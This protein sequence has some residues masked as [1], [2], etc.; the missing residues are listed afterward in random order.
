MKNSSMY[1]EIMDQYELV[2]KICTKRWDEAREINLILKKAD[3]IILMGTGASLNA[4][5]GAAE[6]ITKY[7]KKMP[8]V[9]EMA[10]AEDIL[11]TLTDKTVCFL[12]SQSGS[13]K[14]TI[15]VAR[16]VGDSPALTIAVT[17]NEDSYLAQ[18]SDRVLLLNSGKEISSATKTQTAQA[19]VMCMAA[20]AG[21]EDAKN[22]LMKLP[23]LIGKAL[24]DLPEIAEEIAAKLKDERAF[25][26]GALGR[27]YPTARQAALLIKEK[28]FILTEGLSISELRHGT[29]EAVYEGMPIFLIAA[30]EYVVEAQKHAEYFDG[31]VGA[32]VFLV[33]D[34]TADT[35]SSRYEI[36]KIENL[37]VNAFC[38]FCPTIF[39]QLLAEKIARLNGYDIDGFRYLSKVVDKY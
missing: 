13:S 34:D 14:E 30:N 16:K 37:R 15:D 33:V 29:V 20:A 3:N 5:H 23:E 10:Q 36:I 38:N 32:K 35:Q 6:A 27:M 18:N 7:I 17:N 2:K 9:L 25:Y 1:N 26:I 4:C 39:F 28:D 21:D 22:E 24:K 11:L 19:L 8:H 31:V 12:V